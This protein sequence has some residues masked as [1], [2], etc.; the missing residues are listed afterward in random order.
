MENSTG[1][2]AIQTSTIRETAT[3][4]TEEPVDIA[5]LPWPAPDAWTAAVAGS[6]LAVGDGLGP[7][8]LDGSRLYLERYLGEE[9]QIAADLVALAGGPKP[10]VD[11]A[12][13]GDG[14]RRLFAEEV[15][16]RQALAAAAAVTARVSVV[17][18]GPGTG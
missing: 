9:R 13:L 18:G 15:A 16:G 11:D 4:D 8:H 6:P 7:L 3:V 2:K 10:A 17:A 14:V 12:L 1:G 5:G